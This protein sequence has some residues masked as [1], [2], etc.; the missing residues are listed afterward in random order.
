MQDK[1]NIL[2][3]GDI[4]GAPGILTVEK[5]LPDLIKKNNIDFVIAQ[6]ENVTGRKGLDQEDYNKLK[7]NG[8]NCFTMGNHVWANEDIYNIINNKDIIRPF[9]ID[10]SYPGHGTSVFKVKDFLLRVSS[11]LGNTFNELNHPWNESVALP[12]LKSAH[13]LMEYNDTDF[14][15][16]DFHAETTSEKYV[17]GLEVDGTIDAVCGTHTHVQTND[18]HILPKGT[19]YIT[20][21][22]TVGP[23]D[24]AIGANFQ[25]VRD[26]M[27]DP[28][29]RKRFQVSPNNTQFNA[30][31]ITLQKNGLKKKTNSIKK[32][33]IFDIDIYEK[34]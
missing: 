8:V 13:K 24:S 28:S 7:K 4:F 11:L 26:K 6:G 16:I 32:I 34:K 9:N 2:F 31:I 15:F 30:V 21:A 29:S 10:S 22:G 5:I 12:F 27:L 20:D 23:I 18:D 1:I 25:E 3:I 33:N 14:H 19:C 17:L